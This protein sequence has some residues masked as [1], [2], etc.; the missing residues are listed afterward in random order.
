MA[1]GGMVTALV[2][3][4]LDY[5]FDKPIEYSYNLIFLSSKS[6]QPLVHTNQ[7]S[8]LNKCRIVIPKELEQPIIESQNRVDQ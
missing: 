5:W 7:S 6:A 4:S 3:Y 8:A 2:D 1:E